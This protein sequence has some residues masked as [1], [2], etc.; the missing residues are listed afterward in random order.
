MTQI[1]I[2][3]RLFG[4]NGFVDNDQTTKLQAAID[5]ACTSRTANILDLPA[6]T[7]DVSSTITTNVGRQACIIRGQ[8]WTFTQG[9]AGITQG[10]ITGGTNIRFTHNGDGFS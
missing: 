6:G 9:D 5:A 3:A 4:V 8:G 2:D 1:G 7:I 10:T